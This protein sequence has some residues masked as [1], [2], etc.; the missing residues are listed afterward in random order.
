MVLT[1]GVREAVHTPT[2]Q[3][4]EKIKIPKCITKLFMKKIHQI[5]TKYLTYIILN[6]KRRNAGRNQQPIQPLT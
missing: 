2:I 3:N 6:L 1:I 4:Y 5:P